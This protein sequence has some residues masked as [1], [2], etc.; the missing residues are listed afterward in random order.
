MV[1]LVW[2]GNAASN[3]PVTTLPPPITP[4]GHAR[5]AA[6]A[7]VTIEQ[8]ADFQC[9]ACAQF[10]RQTEPQLL[11]V[12]V[13]N[14][15]VALVFHHMAFL[16]EESNRAA[17]AAECAGEQGQFFAFHDKLYASQ[18]GENR[19][20]FSKDNLK[21]FGAELGLGAA[22]ATCVDSGR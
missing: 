19:G 12:Y 15:Q 20:T 13:A 2:A 3:A 22:F 7:P 6:S 14:G 16:G 21:G 10:A 17:E 11:S 1:G 8:W 5:A 4:N 18:A 9:P